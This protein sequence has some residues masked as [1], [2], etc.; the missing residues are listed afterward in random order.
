M[1]LKGKS[2]HQGWRENPKEASHALSCFLGLGRRQLLPLGNSKSSH[3]LKKRERER[4]T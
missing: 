3:S 1:N 2:C 4:K